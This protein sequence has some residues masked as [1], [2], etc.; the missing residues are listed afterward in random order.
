[1]HWKNKLKSLK[2]VQN[3]SRTL[4][5]PRLLIGDLVLGFGGRVVRLRNVVVFTV[6]DGSPA[7][8]Q[9]KTKQTVQ[10]IHIVEKPTSLRSRGRKN[11]LKRSYG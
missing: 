2:R 6:E 1:M 8:K 4:A 3:A 11:R 7:N 5:F 9:N 10:T